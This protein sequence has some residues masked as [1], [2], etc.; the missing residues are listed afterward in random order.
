[1]GNEKSVKLSQWPGSGSVSVNFSSSPI[2]VIPLAY[3]K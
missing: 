3:V 2:F 1:V